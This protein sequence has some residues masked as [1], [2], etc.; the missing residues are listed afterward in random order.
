MTKEE[1]KTH[2]E[3]LDFVHQVV[4]VIGQ[5]GANGTY[6]QVETECTNTENA[7]QKVVDALHQI[8]PT[9][10]VWPQIIQVK[11]PTS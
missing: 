7:Y 1:I 10:K 4:Q 3:A 11:L 2:L 6:V 8:N 5:G 9:M